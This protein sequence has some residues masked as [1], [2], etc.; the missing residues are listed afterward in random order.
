MLIE[1]QLYILPD[2]TAVQAREAFRGTWHLYA[3]D[4]V[5]V[6]LVFGG[7]HVR[8]LVYTGS[9]NDP[10][11]TESTAQIFEAVPCDLTIGDLRPAAAQREESSGE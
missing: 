7:N 9:T 5:P 3:A 4:G 1:G 10:L 8:R 2:G 6:Y 11:L